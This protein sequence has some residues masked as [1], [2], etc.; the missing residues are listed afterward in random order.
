MKIKALKAAFPAT[1]PTLTGFAFLGLAFGIY[2]NVSGFSFW[3]PMIMGIVVYG[4]SLEFVS[5]SMLLAPYAPLQ[6]FIM[7]LAIQARHIFYGITM[8]KKFENTGKFKPYLIFGM[9]DETFSINYSAK[10]SEGVDNDLFMFFVTL[11]NQIYWV[12][13]STVGGIL[14]SLITI[15]IQGID[16]VMTAMFTVIF[17]EQWLKE[18]NHIPSLI[19]I[20]A[21]VICLIIF[22]ADNFLVPTMACIAIA[23]MLSRKTLTKEGEAK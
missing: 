11:L 2:M 3:Y 8:L 22:G 21:S 18:K 5:V 12:V 17:V 7:A 4:G 6:T 10:R 19:G 23:L 20:L 9:C 16:F 13:S 1:I 14:G 15:D